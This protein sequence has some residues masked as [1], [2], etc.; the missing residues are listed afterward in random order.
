MLKVSREIAE[1][2][3]GSIDDRQRKHLLR[4]QM[5]TIQTELGEGDA[6]NHAEVTP[7]RYVMIVVSDSGHGM[8]EA[9]RR[10]AFEPFFTTKERGRGTG[11]PSTMTFSPA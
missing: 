7:G 1:R 4:E 10:R 11:S 2:T 3:K 9:T 5:R 6:P 8:D